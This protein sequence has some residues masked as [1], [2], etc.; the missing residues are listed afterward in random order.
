MLLFWHTRFVVIT[1]AFA[2]TVA[3]T[4]PVL[5]LAGA[6]ELRSLADSVSNQLARWPTKYLCAGLNLQKP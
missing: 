3:V 1:D 4:I 2:S 6:V 5:M